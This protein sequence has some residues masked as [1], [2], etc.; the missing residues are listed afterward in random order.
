MADHKSVAVEL[1]KT[2]LRQEASET[3]SDQEELRAVA[4]QMSVYL[5]ALT[6]DPSAIQQ[7]VHARNEACSPKS[8]REIDE[9]W[10][11]T[12]LLTSWAKTVPVQAPSSINELLGQLYLHSPSIHSTW[13]KAVMCWPTDTYIRFSVGTIDDHDRMRDASQTEWAWRHDASLRIPFSL[14]ECGDE[15]QRARWCDV[16]VTCRSDDGSYWLI[17]QTLRK[18]EGAASWVIQRMHYSIEPQDK[19]RRASIMVY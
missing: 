8:L 18:S 6:G 3:R 16:G 5:A 2:W 12:A 13:P 7:Y 19:D 15:T 14:Y 9:E 4:C 1:E 17:V 11:Y 10:E